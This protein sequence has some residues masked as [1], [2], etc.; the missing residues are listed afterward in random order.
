M[1]WMCGGFKAVRP[2]G[3]KVFVYHRLA[4]EPA[5]YD[6]NAA[7]YEF[8]WHGLTAGRLTTESTW[9]K[10]LKLLFTLDTAETIT[11]QDL[12]DI[13]LQIA[14]RIRAVASGQ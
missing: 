3:E 14:G 7:F 12:L 13:S 5:R 2:D 11:E 8:R 10:R 4:W 6:E 9:R 1:E